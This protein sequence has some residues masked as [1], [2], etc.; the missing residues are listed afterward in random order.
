MCIRDR[1]KIC[2]V[3]GRGPEG[4]TAT[5][6]QQVRAA[7]HDTVIAQRGYRPKSLS[8]P[9][10]GLDAVMFHRGQ[11]P[12]LDIRR[13]WTGRP[14]NEVDWDD[15]TSMAPVMVLSLIHI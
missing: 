8:T 7:V 13:R 14:A 12:A 6:Y 5:Q 10:F 3:T 11:A 1:A 15:L 2:I 9:L 4:L